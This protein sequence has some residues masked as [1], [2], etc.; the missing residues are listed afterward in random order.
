MICPMK[1]CISIC[2]AWCGFKASAV[3]IHYPTIKLRVSFRRCTDAVKSRDL[4]A[5][6]YIFRYPRSAVS[7][8]ATWKRRHLRSSS[9]WVLH[10]HVCAV[11][12]MASSVSV[13]VRGMMVP[14]VI[15]KG[16]W[17]FPVKALLSCQQD[18]TEHRPTLT[19]KGK[20]PTAGQG[21]SYAV[22]G[23]GP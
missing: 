22:L 15:S 12:D 18:R 14:P 16:Y 7:D 20:I 13:P 9:D 17:P 3:M 8:M 19:R 11:S 5:N 4:F 6:A 23:L 10:T 1:K 2:K 21:L